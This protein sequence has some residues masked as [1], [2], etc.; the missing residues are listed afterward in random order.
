MSTLRL[1]SSG[2]SS[3]PGAT[4]W[5]LA[6]LGEFRGKQELYTRQSPQRLKTLREHALIESAIS[7]NRMEG[8][9]VDPRRVR[10]VLASPKPL[11][12]DR[13]E[14]EVRGYREALTLIH[15]SSADLPISEETVCRLHRLARGQVWDAGCYKAK[16]GDI[17]ERYANGRERVRFRSVS[18]AETPRFMAD[19]VS[20]WRRCLEERWVH[21]LIAVAA[22]NLD[23]LC[24]H[25]F[26]DGNGRVSRLLL[27]L[28]CYHLGYEVGRYVS[29]ERLIEQNKERYYETLE[30]SSQGWH[31]GRHDPWPYI[32]FIL[33]I[34]KIAYR[35]FVERVGDIRAP[36]GSKTEMVLSALERLAK[37]FTLAQLEQACPGVS[38]ELVRRVLNQQKGKTVECIGRGP[39]AKWMKKG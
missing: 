37:E 28:Q 19:L 8:V 14:E 10:D 12:R 30:Q 25:P 3:I 4:S 36:R 2:N 16:D 29:L 39:G 7:S 34:L 20:N 13:D 38:R 9:E 32:N 23:F 17:I 15:E 6:D 26:R 33:F 11:F 27:L 21:P 24:I 1:F 5:Y 18:A 22:F 31:E 35:E